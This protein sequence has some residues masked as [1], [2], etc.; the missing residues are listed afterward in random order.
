[1]S[2]GFIP[3]L[4]CGECILQL[5]LSGLSNSFDI[6]AGVCRILVSSQPTYKW[7]GVQSL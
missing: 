2:G 1:M 3:L 5:Q 4:R 6:V 7:T